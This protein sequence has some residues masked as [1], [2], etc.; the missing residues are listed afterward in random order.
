MPRLSLAPKERRG[1][2][3]STRTALTTTSVP[4]AN[5]EGGKEGKGG[6]GKGGACR[7]PRPPPL[8]T[9]LKKRPEGP[10]SKCYPPPIYYVVMSRPSGTPT[11]KAC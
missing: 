2:A 1:T 4:W 9:L 10:S 7:P 6:K 3:H 8:L 11:L 5:T